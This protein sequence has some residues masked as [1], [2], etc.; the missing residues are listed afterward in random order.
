MNEDQLNAEITRLKTTRHWRGLDELYKTAS[1]GSLELERRLFFDW[2]RATLLATELNA[3]G[4]AIAVLARAE[5]AGGPLDL[6]AP[7][8]EAIR[9]AAGGETNTIAQQIYQR[10]LSIYPTHSLS[11]QI[12]EWSKALSLQSSP[13]EDDDRALD[14]S[15]LGEDDIVDE[16]PSQRGVALEAEETVSDPVEPRERIWSQLTQSSAQLTPI[17]VINLVRE[18]C[19]LG[20]LSSQHRVV[21]EPILWKA[22]TSGAQW[23]L[24]TQL[25]EQ[26]FLVAPTSQELTLDRTFQLASIFEIELKEHDRSIELYQLVIDQD[27]THDEAFDRLRELLRIK[28]SWDMLGRVLLKFAKSSGSTRSH[29]DRFEMCVEAGDYYAQQLNNMPKALT[30]WFQ[31][32]EI[33]PESKQVLVRLVEIYQKAGKWESCIKVLRKLSA[34]EEDETKAAFNLYQ[35]GTIQR[36]Q[37][38]DHYLAVRTFDEALDRDVNFVKAFQAIDDTLGD[39]QNDISVIERRDRYYRKMLIR[40]VQNELDPSLI[41]ELGLQIGSMNL[42]VLNEL[43]EARRAYELV[44]DYEPMRDQAHLGLVEITAQLEGPIASIERAF[45][46]VRRSPSQPLAY[47]GLFERSM[48]AQQWDR[49]W[50]ATLALDLLG[51][52]HPEVREHF[53]AGRALLGA[54]LGRGLDAS[55]WRLLEWSG[56]QWGGSGDEWGDIVTQLL[57]ILPPLLV[58]SHKSWKVNPKRDRIP[59]DDSTTIGRVAQYISQ[60]LNLDRPMIWLSSSSSGQLLT[61]ISVQGNVGL[62]LNREIIKELSIEQLACVLAYGISISQPSRWLAGLEQRDLIRFLPRYLLQQASPTAKDSKLTHQIA[63]QLDRLTPDIR[64]SLDT[65]ALKG[66]DIE[67]WLIAIEQTALR[68]SLLICGDPSLLKKLMS[69][70]APISTDDQEERLYKLLLFSVSPPYIKL[71]RQLKLAW[72]SHS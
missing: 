29:R 35:I 72:E 68:A 44:L 22:A 40:A 45:A 23:R 33:E 36:D 21:L 20:S 8:V 6:I 43:E 10:W 3:P 65:L 14:E 5:Q 15:L 46:W 52:P 49:A 18:F 24:W 32:L 4:E 59:D 60:S 26:Y 42:E 62:A 1:E 38:N 50:C 66:G 56:F 16:Q 39:D 70:V 30:S 41:A 69:G 27:P 67:S 28:Q 63:Q 34:L 51:S 7:Q 55:E 47:L 13:N 58:K 37:L 61:P 31:A 53:E 25:F 9:L 57:P 64:A 17:A 2:E 71:R 19:E 11:I 48:Q 12:R 54:R